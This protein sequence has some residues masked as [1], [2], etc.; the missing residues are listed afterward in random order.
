MCTL[1]EKEGVLESMFC[2]FVKMVD[3]MDHSNV[4]TVVRSDVIIIE[5]ANYMLVL[6]DRLSTEEV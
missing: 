1:F 5:G 4:T 3:T 2:T 6:R